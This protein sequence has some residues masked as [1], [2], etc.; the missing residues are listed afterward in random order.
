WGRRWALSVGGGGG[1]GGGGG[2]AAVG[3]GRGASFLAGS[4]FGASLGWA[5]SSL[6]SRAPRRK[7][8]RSLAFTRSPAMGSGSGMRRSRCA[9]MVKRA[10][11]RNAAGRTPEVAN[12]LRTAAPLAL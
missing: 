6:A 9:W 4:V 12:P 1:G 10:H 8:G 2:A 11:A 3:V 5:S 7:R